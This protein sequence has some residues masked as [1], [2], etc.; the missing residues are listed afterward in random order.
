[1]PCRSEEKDLIEENSAIYVLTKKKAE[2]FAESGSAKEGKAARSRYWLIFDELES[3]EIARGKY[4][5]L[6]DEEGGLLQNRATYQA[7]RSLP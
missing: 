1:M 5:R 6:V 4:F 7:R 2:F 3:E